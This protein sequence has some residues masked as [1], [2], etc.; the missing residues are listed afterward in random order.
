MIFLV[1]FFTVEEINSCTHEL[2]KACGP[3]GGQVL[4]IKGAS[5][6]FCKKLT[7]VNFNA[8]L[9]NYLCIA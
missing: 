1:S 6:E 9:S 8:F 5:A 3:T 7:E 4:K 2:L